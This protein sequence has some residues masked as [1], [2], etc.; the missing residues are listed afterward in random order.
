M[1]KKQI[2]DVYDHYIN[3][4]GLYNKSTG[5]AV[6]SFSEVKDEFI[7]AVKKHRYDI[8]KFTIAGIKEAKK[9]FIIKPKHAEAFEWKNT[10]DIFHMKWIGWKV[11]KI[12]KMHKEG[13]KPFLVGA[14][15]N[16]QDN[17]VFAN[18][19]VEL[20][21]KLQIYKKETG[22]S[23]IPFVGKKVARL[24]MKEVRKMAMQEK[25]ASN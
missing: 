17:R 13:P 4:V 12:K 24:S 7:A 2:G 23:L 18:T 3:P 21:E 25:F 14:T 16:E 20:I 19:A 9:S 22:V 6:L 15:I 1:K 8:K 11:Q 10:N 5:E